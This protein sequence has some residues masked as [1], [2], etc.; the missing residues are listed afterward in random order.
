MSMLPPGSPSGRAVVVSATTTSAV[1]TGLPIGIGAYQLEVSNAGT[2][3]A[4]IAVEPAPATGTLTAIVPTSGR[5]S[6]PILSGQSKCYTIGSNEAVA[7]VSDTTATVY[8]Q[9]LNGE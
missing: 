1:V 9:V 6:A 3:T 7:V 5:C 4:F 8:F 2:G